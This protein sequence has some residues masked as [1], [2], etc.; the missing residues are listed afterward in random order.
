M[1]EELKE[2]ILSNEAEVRQAIKS[3]LREK[4]LI[5]NGLAEF[6]RKIYIHRI[7]GRPVE[8]DSIVAVDSAF[9]PSPIM[10]TSGSIAVIAA[11][12]V[13]ERGEKI[14]YDD[15][16][17]I[18]YMPYGE[19]D[20]YSIAGRAR[21]LERELLAQILEKHEASHVIIDG[22]VFTYTRYRRGVQGRG[23]VFVRKADYITTRI[24]NT[25]DTTI[26]GIIKRD[27]SRKISTRFK[28]N[29]SDRSLFTTIL[30][31][32]EYVIIDDVGQEHNVRCKTV[33]YKPFR[34]IFD[35]ALRSEICNTHNL[36][37]D[38]A[39]LASLANYTGLP[40]HIDLVDR[41]VKR[42]A[43]GVAKAITS[44][45][46]S[47]SLESSGGHA[48]TLLNPQEIFRRGAHQHLY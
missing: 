5:N 19:I 2:I 35:A 16:I 20:P 3:I 29:I 30:R 4:R 46:P 6:R 47:E 21:L 41:R 33:Y 8:A 10:F 24:M 42:K 28:L 36:E 17:L 18:L 15:K 11:S 43:A 45:I 12:V 14:S 26:I 25:M 38:L 7:P 34:A 9:T 39:L 31:R 48:E 37:G 27:Y 32:G 1:S 23:L 22:E 13:V 40:L 44:L